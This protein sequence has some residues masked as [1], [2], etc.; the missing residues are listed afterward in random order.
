MSGRKVCKMNN[1]W[2]AIC[3]KSTTKHIENFIL[4]KLCP[5]EDVGPK[6][7]A[8]PNSCFHLPT[9]QYQTYLDASRIC[10]RASG[11]ILNELTP[12]SVFFLGNLMDDFSKHMCKDIKTL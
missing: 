5:T 11:D 9:K 10:E 12:S 1:R 7:F 2:I 3:F 4:P 6:W 8:G